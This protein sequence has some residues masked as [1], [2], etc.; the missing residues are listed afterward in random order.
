MADNICCCDLTP[1]PDDKLTWSGSRAEGSRYQLVSGS[2]HVMAIEVTVHT[3]AETDTTAVNFFTTPEP[4]DTA[5]DVNIWNLVVAKGEGSSANTP[6]QFAGMYFE[7]GIFAEVMSP[8][9]TA[10]VAINIV[11]Y[12]RDTYIPAIPERPND[13]RD[14]LWGCYNGEEPYGN[15]FPPGNEGDDYSDTSSSTTMGTLTGNPIGD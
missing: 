15:N 12:K 14:R 7:N 13:R 5:E 10:E 11:Y 6:D 9:A 2:C 4:T 1:H 3:S 8:D